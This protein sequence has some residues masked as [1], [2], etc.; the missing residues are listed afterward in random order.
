MNTVT[1]TNTPQTSKAQCYKQPFLELWNEDCFETLKK[2]P[3]NSVNCVIIDPPYGILTGH[4]IEQI[5]DIDALFSEIK[6]VAAPNAFIA[7]FG[8]MPTILNW[9]N[10]GLIYFKYQDEITWVKRSVTAITQP[11][12][13]QKETIIILKKGNPKYNITKDA[14]EDVKIPLFLNG[15][16]DFESIKRAISA[17]LSNNK[18]K[19]NAAKKTNDD[20]YNNYP[21]DSER[22]P[23]VVNYT[24][25]WSF[26]PQN[27][28]SFN[29]EK[30]NYK[31]PTVKPTLLIQRLLKL[32]SND[33]DLILDC[34]LGSGT[35]AEAC[36]HEKRNFIG[37]EIDSEYFKMSVERLKN[38]PMHLF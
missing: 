6:R 3:S 26:M 38:I 11:I 16:Y 30:D 28:V 5:I 21:T 13:R 29:T 18:I 25:V 35:T 34:F 27:K 1:D 33:S 17:R 2:I 19:S 8:Q 20:I 7:F 36:L 9:I 4:K 10:I 15:L 12:I 23:E 37:S 31:H 14:Y 32:L 22:C 24:N